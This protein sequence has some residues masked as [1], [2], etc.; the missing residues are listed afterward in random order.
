ML[1]RTK[2]PLAISVM[3]VCKTQSVNMSCPLILFLSAAMACISV[4]VAWFVHKSV[5]GLLCTSVYGLGSHFYLRLTHWVSTVV[6]A[7][8][9]AR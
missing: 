9:T 7:A 6:A 2:C 1:N 4:Y 8:L 5:Y 3:S